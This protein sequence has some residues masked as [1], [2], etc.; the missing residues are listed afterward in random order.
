MKNRFQQEIDTRLADL[1]FTR[2]AEVLDRLHA[3]R[4]A[5]PIPKRTVALILA[6]MLMLCGTAVALTLRYSAQL[7]LERH[8]RGVLTSK[9][10]L[11]GEMIDLFSPHVE[12]DGANWTVRYLPIGWE[13]QM[14]EYTVTGS[15]NGDTQATWSHDGEEL[16]DSVWGPEQLQQF[17]TVRH[18]QQ[19]SIASAASAGNLGN[20]TLEEMAAI[21]APL[22]NLP[23]AAGEWLNVVPGEDDI[24]QADAERMAV[25]AVMTKWGIP[26]AELAAC[27]IRTHFYLYP[28]DG[29]HEYRIFVEGG[30]ALGTF[31]VKIASPSGEITRNDWWSSPESVRL[32]EG[33]L[34][35]YPA[36]A[37]EFVTEGGFD[38][39]PPGGK[40]AVYLRYEAAGLADLLP[41]GVY[42][43]PAT[44]DLNE[45]AAITRAKKAM[46]ET[47]AF[48]AEAFELFGVR[49]AMLRGEAGREWQVRF[50]GQDQWPLYW[51]DH[52]TL[53]EYTVTVAA[54]GSI[55]RCEWS[56]AEQYAGGYTESTFG[57]SEVLAGELLTW[58]LTLRDK[59]NQINAK[60]PD[61]LNPSDDMSLEDLAAYDG[62][63]RDAGFDPNSYPH[64]LP[65]EGEIQE[66][67]AIALARQVLKDEYGLT[68]DIL[69]HS[70]LET[71]FWMNAYISDE[72]IKGWSVVYKGAEIYRVFIN[73][74]DGII[75]EVEHDDLSLGNG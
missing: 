40:A 61:L 39:L 75:E 57:Q 13:E 18:A 5:R 8:T 2:E 70:V 50:I 1:T 30:Y 28:E 17:M 10:G 43:T 67:E 49:T 36:A 41:P 53:G 31:D 62:L 9:Y 64:L 11:T 46:A 38:L 66:A 34:A 16:S 54:D 19:S 23:G 21:D 73:A 42:V 59:L 60:Y 55:M 74:A 44:T 56:L 58:A 26:A 20:L 3:R 48:P 27:K 25:E 4:Q 15:A 24:Q 14:G 68:D 7:D 37:E 63:M 52:D 71:S 45:Q 6:L 72:P 29:H 47:Y 22:L 69:D 51:L 12:R 35:Q 65:E 32:P 33:D